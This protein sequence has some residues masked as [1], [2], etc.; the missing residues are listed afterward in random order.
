MK[1]YLDEKPYPSGIRRELEERFLSFAF[2][3]F[4][5]CGREENALPFIVRS[6]IHHT[7]DVCRIGEYIMENDPRWKNTSPEERFTGYCTCLAH[8]LSRFP[9]YRDFG[10]L[11][12]EL[13]FDHGEKSADILRKRQFLLPGFSAGELEKVIRAVGV[14][15]KRSIPEEYP[16]EER[17]LAELVRDADKLSI[18]KVVTDHFDRPEEERSKD[19]A[20]NVPDTPGCTEEVLEMAL[21]GKGVPYTAIR[22]VND[23]KIIVFQWPGDLNFSAGAKYALEHDLFGH[24]ASFLPAHPKMHLLVD[25]TMHSLQK[26]AGM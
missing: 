8:D 12:D 25:M 1:N 4:P 17:L 10:T 21:A 22:C 7:L 13:S 15:N 2:A 6:K 18:L 23:F 20:L 19:V 9:Q 5:E 26:L 24:F 3:Y 11:R 14:H 16:E